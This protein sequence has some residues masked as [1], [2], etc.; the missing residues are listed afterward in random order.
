MKGSK[1]GIVV[2]CVVALFLVLLSSCGSV[3]SE[4]NKV[5]KTIDWGDDYYW[6]SKTESVQ[7]TLWSYLD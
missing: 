7:R 5:G 3:E 6:D 1:R 2:F 4:R